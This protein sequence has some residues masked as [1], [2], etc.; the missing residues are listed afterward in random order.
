[1]TAWTIESGAMAS[2]ATWKTH[3]PSAT[4]MPIANHFERKRPTALLSGCFMLTSG[5][6][7]A[8]RCFS[9]KPTFVAN[10]QKIA[11]RIP[12]ESKVI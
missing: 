5:A 10:A 3:A 4:S 7:Q 12:S 6:A 8:P 9:R 2:A 1:M 11:R